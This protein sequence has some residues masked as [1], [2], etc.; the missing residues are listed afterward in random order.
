M[1]ISLRRALVFAALSAVTTPAWQDSR[2]RVTV[3]LV[4][5]DVSVVDDHGGYPVSYLKASDFRVLL[6]G[7]P[8][9][10][11][12]SNFVR[13]KDVPPVAADPPADP[14]SAPAG[15]PTMPSAP[16]QRDRVNRTIVLFVGDQL[17]SSES[18]PAIRAGLTKFVLEQGRPGDLVAIV[19]SSAGLGALQDF[20]TDEG[21]LLAAVDQVPLAANAMGA[22]MTADRAAI[23]TTAALLQLVRRLAGLPGRKSVVLIDRKST[24]LN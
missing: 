9:E 3:N 4:E 15:Q 2:L 20:T 19:R 7:Q 23:E 6:D 1:R 11:K 21:M 13:T 10:I 22:E 14:L 5:L 8:Q 18:I 16:I 12:Y 17:T 24:R